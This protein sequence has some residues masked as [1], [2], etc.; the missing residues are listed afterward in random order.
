[1]KT[2]TMATDH[3]HT[4]AAQAASTASLLSAVA[5]HKQTLA[6][7]DSYLKNRAL[8]AMADSLLAHTE[9]ILRE[10]ARDLEQARGSISPVMLDRLAL[11]PARLS[12]MA[13]SLRDVAALPDPVGQVLEER[14]RP[15]GLHITKVSV[16]I[17]LVAMIYESRPNVTSDAA[18]LAL[19]SGNVC[20][21]RGGKEAIHSN[22]A[23]VAVLKRAL[24]D[25]GL[26]G[27]VLAIA[28]DTSRETAT[29]LMR[30]NE[31]IDLL[32]PRG[33]KGLIRSVVENATIPTI[34]TGAGNC[35]AYVEKSADLE[36]AL[37]IIRN[38]K[39]SR[40]AVCNALEHVLVDRAIAS[41]FLP[42][43]REALPE[44]LLKGDA[45]AADILGVEKVDDDE[46]FTEYDDLIL[47]VKVVGGIEEAIAHINSH[48]TKHSDVILTTDIRKADAFTRSIDSAAVYVNA[49]TRF[50][51]GGEFGFG[52]EI[53]IS[54]QKLHARG[55]MGLTELTTIKYIVT[56][57][58]QIR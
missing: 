12:A 40:P 45:E 8:L 56:G 39:T 46:F 29:E 55:P 52:A 24:E 49:S 11:T 50:T 25:S 14:V 27:D 30:M 21:L 3:I 58:G 4:T 53:G 20:V 32:I 19:K 2:E 38:G 51:D 16:P 35:N 54:T 57:D 37:S 23:I 15:N 6:L 13:A 28:E 36:T 17:G 44:V 9:D 41:A 1:M 26:N 34:E 43:L 22:L 48:S 42:R 47:S 33:G 31:F 5:A 10:N 18:S 7:A